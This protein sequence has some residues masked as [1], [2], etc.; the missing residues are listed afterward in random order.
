MV[1]EKGRAQVSHRV[2]NVGSA[3]GQFKV[4]KQEVK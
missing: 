2:R 4:Y 3:L 1:E